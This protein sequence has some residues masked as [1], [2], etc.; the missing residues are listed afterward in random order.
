MSLQAV[1]AKARRSSAAQLAR[2]VATVALSAGLM[3]SSQR[4]LQDTSVATAKTPQKIQLM[5]P[6]HRWWTIAVVAM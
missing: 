4:N 5:K 6:S 3:F 2:A 1:I